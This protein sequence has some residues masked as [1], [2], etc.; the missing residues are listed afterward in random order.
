MKDDGEEQLGHLLY[1][2]FHTVVRL[3]QQ[4]RVIDEEWLDV[5]R[6]VR[7]GSCHAHHL[8]LLRSLIVTDSRCPPFDFD[9]N[10]WNDAILVTPRHAVR[11]QWNTEMA[12]KYCRENA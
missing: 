2:Q 5:L 12:F 10:P 8:Q 9:S 4:V 11:R 6:H 1:E 3:T 7:N